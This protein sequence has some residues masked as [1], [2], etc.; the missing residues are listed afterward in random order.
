MTPTRRCLCFRRLVAGFVLLSTDP[1]RASAAAAVSIES[2]PFE[3]GHDVKAGKG[4]GSGGDRWC[5]VG[6]LLPQ[7]PATSDERSSEWSTEHVVEPPYGCSCASI[8]SRW[9]QN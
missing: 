5:G 1:S 6:E 9:D 2:L 8:K 4:D 7:P 3:S